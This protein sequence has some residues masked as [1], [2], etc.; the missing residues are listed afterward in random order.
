MSKVAKIFS[1]VALLGLIAGMAFYIISQRQQSVFEISVQ[2]KIHYADDP[3]MEINSVLI[4]AF[5][6]VP[7]DRQEQIS[8]AW[9]KNLTDTMTELKKFY[10]L[11]FHHAVSIDFAVYPQ[12]IIGKLGGLDYDGDAVALGN[13]SALLRIQDELLIRVFNPGGDLYSALFADNGSL[14][15]RV[16]GILYEGAGSTATIIKKDA[17]NQNLAVLSEGS[18]PT[19]LASNYYLTSESYKDYGQTIFA[20]EFGHTLGLPDS[21]DLDSNIPSSED[22]MGHGRYRPLSITHLSLEAKAKLGLTY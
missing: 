3:S 5:Y 19:F 9:Q 2:N 16:I 12:P 20:H 15:F 14:S 6:F 11:Q 21:Y 18:L 10:E 7:N 17:Q 8:I 4:K 1:L 22:I 13:P